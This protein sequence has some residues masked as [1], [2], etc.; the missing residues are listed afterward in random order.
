VR[1]GHGRDRRLEVMFDLRRA[2]A[3]LGERAQ[4]GEPGNQEKRRAR[5]GRPEPEAATG[6][7]Q[8]RQVY[9]GPDGHADL[10]DLLGRVEGAGGKGVIRGRDHRF[11]S[12]HH[13]RDHGERSQ[14]V[15]DAYPPRGEPQEPEEHEAGDGQRDHRGQQVA[16]D[17]ARPVLLPGRPEVRAR[18]HDGQ[19]GRGAEGHVPRVVRHRAALLEAGDVARPQLQRVFQSEELDLDLHSAEQAVH[20]APPMRLR[21]RTRTE[22]DG[23]AASEIAH[24]QLSRRVGLDHGMGP[25]HA[26]VEEDEVVVR[27]PAHADG[28]P[29]QELLPHHH[30]VIQD[31]DGDHGA[32][33]RRVELSA[34]SVKVRKDAGRTPVMCTATNAATLGWVTVVDTRS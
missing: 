9:D 29:G 20:A 18:Q 30:A 2:Q 12:R 14:R 33:T 7:A 3:P 4:P 13:E 25:G 15:G 5:P 27:R 24:D 22:A 31:A 34:R 26:G 28:K 19:P 1:T 21:H 32:S 8:G 10:H 11:R 17:D 23:V 6:A 16:E